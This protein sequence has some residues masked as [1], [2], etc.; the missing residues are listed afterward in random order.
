MYT[1]T[2][3]AI[4]ERFCGNIGEIVFP[5]QADIVEETALKELNKLF[6]G[7][8]LSGK[9]KLILGRAENSKQ[10][11]V[12]CESGALKLDG[13]TAED[14]GFH[15][16]QIVQDVVIAGT[17]PRAVLHG[18]YA[19]EDWLFEDTG[20]RLD[21][22]RVPCFRKRSDG[23]GHYHSVS[24]NL[25]NDTINDAKAEYL[26]RLGI[27]QFCACLDGSP[28][29]SYLSEFVKSDIFPFQRAPD[30]EAVDKIKTISRTCR[31]YGID[32]FMMLWEPALP[33]HFASLEKYPQEALGRV[34]RPWGGDENNIDVT[35]CV[36]SPIVKEHYINTVGKFVREFPD[37]AGIF[38]YGLDGYSWLC[39]PE[40]CPRC[41]ENLVDSDPS[42]YNP[43]ETQANFI[44]LIS[45]AAHAERADFKVNFWG[46][47]N[48]HGEAVRK[49]YDTARGY[50]CV[51]TGAAGGDHDLHITNPDMPCLEVTETLKASQKYGVQA[52]VYYAFNRL[53]AIQIGFPSPFTVADSLKTFKRWGFRNVMEVTGPTPA[54]NQI[55]ALVMK[56]FESDTDANVENYLHELAARQYGEAA[57]ALAYRSWEHTRDAFECWKYYDGVSPLCGSQFISRISSF[58]GDIAPAI[59]PGILDEFDGFYVGI[60]AKVEPWNQHAIEKNLSSEFLR[61]FVEMEACLEKAEDAA[62][63]ATALAPD[64]EK[65]GICY[66]AGSFEGLGRPTMREY[67]RL[68]LA[69]IEQAHAICRQKINMLRAVALLRTMR[70]GTADEAAKA[71][72]DYFSLIADDILLH[73]D[74]AV[75]LRR[76]LR[77]RPCLPLTGICEDELR[78][79]LSGTTNRLTKLREYLQQNA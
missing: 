7:F 56:K 69:A 40:L 28:F 20:K 43:W 66:Y 33:A 30:T 5:E 14:D 23:L 59:L 76:L 11:K 41:S 52:F 2:E 68:S 58:Y 9:G 3:R 47:A 17:N 45:E 50:D 44:T 21:I 71:R 19:L 31:R 36:N 16:R 60:L 35:L 12:L 72:K 62:R 57:G 67:A 25:G 26:S 10:I 8:K 51:T 24:V 63:A 54:L 34:K 53:E 1:D 39:T 64:D 22:F 49:M 37:V 79:Y 77:Q 46:P 32:F 13:V 73:Q 61:R 27:N 70:D 42:A 15:I 55:N 75:L 48:F 65:T 38:T 4:I 78:L 74:Y 18:V 29:G 6:F